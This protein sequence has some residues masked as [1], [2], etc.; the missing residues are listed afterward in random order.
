MFFQD[1]WAICRIF[2][3]TNSVAQRALAHTWVSPIP[4]ASGFTQFNSENVSCTTEMGSVVNL[5]G[6]NDLQHSSS[7]G[8]SPFDI[9]CYKPINSGFYKPSEIPSNFMFSTAPEVS[10][11][12]KCTIDTSSSMLL[13]SALFGDLNKASENLDFG[14][15]DQVRGFSISMS[16]EMQGHTIVEED[17]SGFRKNPNPSSDQ[18]GRFPFSLS[19]PNLSWDSPPC[20]SEL[21][22]TYSPNNCYT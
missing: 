3:K 7:S 16:Q 1:A 9:P 22:T 6:N 13:N 4:E 15:S 18:W 2:K 14:G 12:N 19:E 11:L 20:P 5:C 10:G 21:S 17:E 8:F